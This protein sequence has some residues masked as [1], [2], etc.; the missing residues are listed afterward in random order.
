MKKVIFVLLAMVI[1]L[2]GFNM[3]SKPMKVSK[4]NFELAEP[5]NLG[6]E[7]NGETEDGHALHIYQVSIPKS[8]NLNVSFDYYNNG[9]YLKIYDT[10]GVELQKDY[11]AYQNALGVANANLD[12]PL[13]KGSYYIVLHG[14]AYEGQ[15]YRLSTS[16]K[17]SGESILE[18][19]GGINNHID[20]ASSIKLNR[21][22]YGQIAYNDQRDVY[23]FTLTKPI[24]VTVEVEA[25]LSGA[26]YAIYDESG[27]RLFEQKG[28]WTKN[29]V[30]AKTNRF[31][32][33]EKVSL[34][35]GTYYFSVTGFE[36][37][38]RQFY[39]NYSFKLSAYTINYKVSYH[40]G[41]DSI[42]EDEEFQYGKTYEL[43]ENQFSKVGYHFSGWTLQRMSDQ[44]WLYAKDDLVKWCEE[45]K[46]PVDYTKKVF[47]NKEEVKNLSPKNGEELKF[48]ARMIKNS[49]TV[50]YHGRGGEGSMKNT[51]VK[52]GNETPLRTNTF[53][54][55]GY[56]F[57]G[58][59]CYR[60]SDKKWFYSDGNQYGWY[61]ENEQP[62]GFVKVVYQDNAKLA[63][64]SAVHRDNV[65]MFARWQKRK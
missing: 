23:S 50:K 54:R 63:K 41:D 9:A 40:M 30:D 37:R 14:E 48:Y 33:K 65:H 46:Q 21:D 45:G 29:S 53:E 13:T 20:Q 19:D 58:W 26:T 24:D 38:K 34:N 61:Q 2:T 59:T 17:G 1:V 31:Q 32:M 3:L 8:G 28:G 27:K 7:I 51:I 47:K 64:T 18:E 11:I 12:Y 10:K 25:K 42:N 55:A 62:K 36:Q 4:P 52:Y 22:Y 6:V 49:F 5:L 44:K 56:D 43:K 15:K 60:S 35:E 57:A 16:Y 39:G